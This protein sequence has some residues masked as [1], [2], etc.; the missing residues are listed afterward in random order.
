MT[1]HKIGLIVAT[2]LVSSVAVAD[3][4]KVE[5][6]LTVSE[7]IVLDK[8]VYSFKANNSSCTVSRAV[9]EYSPDLGMGLMETR[10]LTCKS[11]KKQEQKTIFCARKKESDSTEVTVGTQKIQLSCNKI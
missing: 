10:T 6:T 1:F 9:K 8:D 5:W 11:G 3:S 2:L 4:F 7:P